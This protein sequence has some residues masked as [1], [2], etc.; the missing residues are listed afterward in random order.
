[1]ILQL[2][3]ATIILEALALVI[4]KEKDP[5][6]FLYWTA[7]TAL[8]NVLVNLCLTYLFS[9]STLQYYVSVTLLEILVFAVEF[10]LCLCYTRDKGK[11]LKYSLVCNLTSYL[12]G[13]LLFL[14]FT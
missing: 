12:V 2:L 6:F 1:M 10:L 9:D 4:L 5:L 3:A 14:I 11:S 8:T 13:T 7:V